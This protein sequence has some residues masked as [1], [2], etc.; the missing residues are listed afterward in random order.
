MPTGHP[1]PLVLADC[2]GYAEELGIIGQG[3]IAGGK[4][5][6]FSSSSIVVFFE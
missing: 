2:S 1:T 5:V 6:L 3:P 4:K